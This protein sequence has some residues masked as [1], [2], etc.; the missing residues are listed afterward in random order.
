MDQKC[1]VDSV[2]K[3]FKITILAFTWFWC[4]QHK[5]AKRRKCG[6]FYNNLGSS[7]FIEYNFWWR[8]VLVESVWC[9]GLT[10]VFGHEQILVNWVS[11][12]I[13]ANRLRV[14]VNLFQHGN[15]PIA[16]SPIFWIYPEL[17]ADVIEGPASVWKKYRVLLST[18]QETGTN[19]K[20]LFQ[21]CTWR[22]VKA[23]SGALLHFQVPR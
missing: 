18:L 21:K 23:R 17:V 15:T 20:I 22:I 7:P 13:S 10:A 12:N 19:F 16:N 3:S 14:G 9:D 5:I 2:K 8:N 11:K 4:I 6:K 1:V